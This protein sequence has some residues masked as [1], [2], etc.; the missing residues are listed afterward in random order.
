MGHVLLTAHEI[1]RMAD[2]Q[3]C[4]LERLTRITLNERG[5][6]ATPKQ[7]ETEQTEV[8]DN[9]PNL[10]LFCYLDILGPYRPWKGVFCLGLI[11][12]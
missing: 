5:D 1:Q 4:L 2:M 9:K 10:S 7:R 11:N 12:A 6:L 8:I 3:D